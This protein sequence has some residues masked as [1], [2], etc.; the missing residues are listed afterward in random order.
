MLRQSYT[1]FNYSL[2]SIQPATLTEPTAADN[3]TVTASVT[4]TGS[5]AGRTTLGVYYSK[6]VSRFVRFHKMLAGFAKLEAPLAPGATTS[7]VVSFSAE[8]VATWDPATKD[9]MIER[10][11][12]Q[13]Y[14]GPDSVTESIV[15]PFVIS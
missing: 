2:V 8:S 12:Y 15:I 1:T 14:V 7:L 13:L 9:Y 4:N 11:E 10:G 6:T 5:A 3:I